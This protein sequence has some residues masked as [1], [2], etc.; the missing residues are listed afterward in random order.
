VGNL[1]DFHILELFLQ[2]GDDL[3]GLVLVAFLWDVEDVVAA[4]TKEI[5][6]THVRFHKVE[7][8]DEEVEI[9]Q[10]DLETDLAIP[11]VFLVPG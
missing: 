3:L 11:N 4:V 2:G 7:K 10:V 1:A 9:L 6:G 5:E 8:A